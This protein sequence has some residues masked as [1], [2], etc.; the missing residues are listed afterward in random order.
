MC[1]YVCMYVYMYVCAYTAAWVWSLNCVGLGQEEAGCW[2]FA[3]FFSL[4]LFRADG[5][6]K[7]G[8]GAWI[9]QLLLVL[10]MLR[11]AKTVYGEKGGGTHVHIICILSSELLAS[12][13]HGIC[14]IKTCLFL[15]LLSSV[16]K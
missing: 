15:L 8:G 1:M 9:R 12:A 6:E 13:C 5:P 10:Q 4:S 14:R 2:P 16:Q 3:L 11:F 7:S